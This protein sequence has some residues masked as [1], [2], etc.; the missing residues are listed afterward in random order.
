MD[1]V[2]I[3]TFLDNQSPSLIHVLFSGQAAKQTFHPPKDG[4][5]P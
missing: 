4:L 5:I 2:H 3:V 1:P